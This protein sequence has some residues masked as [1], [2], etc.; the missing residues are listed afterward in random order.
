[1][2]LLFFANALFWVSGDNLGLKHPTN[3]SKWVTFSWG[4]KETKAGFLIV[5]ERWRGIG[6][7]GTPP[8]SNNFFWNPPIKTDA[9]PWGTPPLKMKPPSFEKQTPLLK[10]EAPFHEMIPRKSTIINNLKSSCNPW[11]MCVKKFIFCKFAGLQAYSQQLYYQMNS[12][13]GI[14]QQHFK[15][16]C[17]LHVLT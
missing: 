10:R 4:S 7:G 3:S 11:K 16:P 1:M 12:L 17:S 5:G 9:P 14:F 6:C 13:I 2:Q 15:P 8:P